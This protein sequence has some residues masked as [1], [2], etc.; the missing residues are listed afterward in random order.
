M[1]RALVALCVR[2]YGAITALT[3]MALILGG[4]GAMQAPLDV[5]PEFVPSQVDVQT[6]APGFAPQQVEELVTR[7]VENAVNGSAGIATMRS[8]S[9]PGLSVVTI[10]FADGIDVHVARQGIAERLSE[11]GTLPAGVGTPKLSPLVSSTMDLL[12]IGLLSDKVDAYTL[13]DQANWIIRPRLLAVPG[14]A[15]VIV[16]GGAVRQIQ[17][18]PDTRKLATFGLTFS[19][20]ADAAKAALPLRGAGLV[21]TAAQR[22]LLKSPTPEPDA[23]A[24]AQAVVGVRNNTPV[25]L[26]DVADVRIAPAVRFGDALIMGKPGVLLSLAS[27]YGA[28]TLN[29]TLEVEKA[30]AGLDPALKKQGIQ[31]YTSLHRP[32][33]FIER[34]LQNLKESLVIAA[35]LILA[36]LYLFLRNAR[37]AFIAFTAIPLSLL[38]AVGVLQ[39]MGLTL[40]TMTLGGFAVAL[41]VLVDDAI[42]GIENIMRRLRENAL[43]SAPRPR[44]EVI[45]EASLEVR[46]PVI[47]ATVVVIAVFLPE[48]FTTSVQGHFVGPLALSFIFA[49]VASLVV[50]LTAT[51]ALC[52]LM[53]RP[54][55][56][57]EARWLTRL[58]S[59]QRSAVQAAFVHLKITLVVLL[60]LVI[61]AAAALPFLG[62]TFMPDFREGHFVMQVSS[63]VTG[64]SLDEM[65]NVGQ[66]ISK[67]VLALPYVQSIEQ[68]IGRAELSE[69]TWGP[70]RSE[71]HV[72]LKPDATINQ[73]VAQDQ[74][75]EILKQYPGIQ[76]EV[77]T[78]L[79]DRIS[80]SLSGETAQVAIKIFGDNLDTLD[81]TADKVTAALGKVK[82]IVDLQFKRQSGT[83]TI[84]IHLVPQALAATGLRVTDVLD[85]IEAAYAGATV[86]QTFSG[87]RTV[88]VV[89]LL[90][91]AARHQPTQVQQL[92]ISSPLGPVPLSRVASVEV[93]TDRYSIQHDSGQR[94]VVVTFNTNGT[95]QDIVNQAQQAISQSV[96]LA[97]G[98]F[99]EFTGAAEAERRTRNELVMYSALALGLIVMIL[100]ISFHWRA[101]SWLVLA[102]L[103]FSLIGSV[104]AIWVTGLGISLGTVVGLVTVFGISA[105]NAILQ[106]AHYE[107]LVE[108]E[109]A[110]WNRELV[111]RGA[112]ERLVPI[113]MTAAV[114]A[115]GLAPLA[116][117]LSRPGQE[118][119]G[120]MAVTVLGGLLSS[121]LLNLLVLPA[122]AEKYVKRPDPAGATAQTA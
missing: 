27:Q 109:G 116:A 112:N 67:E 85:T 33:T 72:E 103:P 17:V 44:L 119:E 100:F 9:I 95:L 115:L 63:S 102:N 34:A 92:M 18:F 11:I 79:G 41:G 91:D 117:M 21:D 105:R 73:S 78:F 26:R 29:T 12:K 86:G 1:M 77:V 47:Y 110:E 57:T 87:T 108:V 6:E 111:M 89:V 30:L 14:V 80:E 98:V 118:I 32:A 51:P 25:L 10:T 28:N 122:L 37:A 83:P 94:L 82:G 90:N 53:L 52:A 74:L 60:V 121:T 49:V 75:R 114:T 48:L 120:P 45:T 97:P 35:V 16:F 36:V 71:F 20:I 104:F 61:G 81:K 54:D 69:D 84:A 56:H 70:H 55:T 101:N 43:L 93:T 76:S 96:A 50:A 64:T 62:G 66:R 23:T 58:K 65:L 7:Q 8:E 15:H 3:L 19:E 4:W 106:L 59:W 113:L 22:I 2:H 38:A 5:F 46:G 68:Q 13:R 24:I 107:H 31:M 39:H 40:N 88:D 42:I 99:V